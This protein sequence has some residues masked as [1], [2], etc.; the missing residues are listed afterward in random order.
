MHVAYCSLLLPEEKRISERAK[1]RLPGISLHKFTSAVI[2]GLEENL[3]DG[4]DVFNIINTRNYPGFPQLLFKTEKWS[5]REGAED[6][7]IGYLN[8]FGIKYITQARGLYRKLRKWVEEKG[9]APCMICVHH[10]FY[11]SMIA[12]LRVKRKFGDRVK[13]CLITGDMN[14]KYG[15]AAQSGKGLKQCLTGI[16]EDRVDKLAT[17][18]DCFVFATKYMAQ[19]FGVE[20]KPYAVVECAYSEPAYYS[21][22]EDTSDDD[23]KIIFYAGALREEYGIPHLLRAFSA[24][25]DENYR[26]WLAGGGNAE[27]MI[28]EFAEKDPRI[29]FLGFIT[30]QEVDLRQKRATALISA[31]TTEH[32]FVKYSFPSKTMEGLASGKPYIAHKLPCEPEEYAQYILYADDESDEAL[33][34]KILQV[35]GL[36]REQRDE[37]SAR[38][39]AFILRQKNPRV[40]CRRIVDMWNVVLCCG[41][42]CL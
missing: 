28:A 32:A 17:E 26:L 13:L 39:R 18:F 41:K 6:W 38:A 40:M 29:E 11:P 31:R 33:R 8:L 10:I 19:A 15:L 12:A 35:C 9:D 25:K 23:E 24:I 22:L 7:H 5:H 34:D 42:E 14:G 16:L 37:I 20:D 2:K 21:A 3:E 4:V 1:K 27:P 36:P 30:P